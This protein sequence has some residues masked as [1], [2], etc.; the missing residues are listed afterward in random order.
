[1]AGEPSAQ[2]GEHG[3]QDSAPAPLSMLSARRAQLE[4]LLA[5]AAAAGATN[6]VSFDTARHSTSAL[7]LSPGLASRAEALLRLNGEEWLAD[8]VAMARS[9]GAG[10]DGNHAEIGPLPV[11]DS[12][13][14][15][16]Q[17]K[18]A[19]PEAVLKALKASGKE[20]SGMLKPR[21]LR[22]LVLDRLTKPKDA[23]AATTRRSALSRKL[24]QARVGRAVAMSSAAARRVPKHILRSAMRNMLR[25]GAS[26]S[27][28]ALA[29]YA[30]AVR[31]ADAT[32]TA[33]QL[34]RHIAAVT[35]SDVAGLVAGEGPGAQESDGHR[36]Q[37]NPARLAAALSELESLPLVP[38]LRR[39]GDLDAE[40]FGDSAAGQYISTHVKSPKSVA[41]STTADDLVALRGKFRSEASLVPGRHA[42]TPPGA[43]PDSR[44]SGRTSSSSGESVHS[45]APLAAQQSDPSSRLAKLQRSIGQPTSKK[46]R[47]AGRRRPRQ[48]SSIVKKW[49]KT[50]PGSF[51][52]LEGAARL[53]FQ[54]SH[55]AAS[56][57]SPLQTV[58][59]VPLGS[60]QQVEEVLAQRSPRSGRLVGTAAV[61]RRGAGGAL[62]NAGFVALAG[63]QAAATTGKGVGTDSVPAT[64]RTL[65]LASR[66]TAQSTQHALGGASG[67]GARR[68]HGD[69]P[70]PSE[71]GGPE[72]PF[73]GGEV[74]V[75][76]VAAAAAAH[77]RREASYKQTLLSAAEAADPPSVA[78]ARGVASARGQASSARTAE[79][80]FSALRA[81]R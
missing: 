80:G 10:D 60:V 75:D 42:A 54:R 29:T 56:A 49:T 61:G 24:R 7:Q 71:R 40:E 68:Q 66:S 30:S 73:M 79:Q 65:T 57:D 58:H 63:S 44:A 47:G 67:E 59:V 1:M 45:S 19:L 74:R 15:A 25:A 76:V 3:A 16:K 64:R 12:A 46:R 27:A 62:V 2:E 9:G 22:E 35:D 70:P 81:A 6:V 48:A 28:S 4:G 39:N 53:E 37:V 69:P 77:A 18:A 20:A 23:V 52:A 17:G 55:E 72:T 8:Q 11:A 38:R 51:S 14:A 5:E 13:V 34:A 41:G 36:E 21:E 32:P 31:G 33:E 26:P 50:A 78:A 43:A